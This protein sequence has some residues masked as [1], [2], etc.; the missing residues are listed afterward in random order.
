MRVLKKLSSLGDKEARY[1]MGMVRGINYYNQGK[2]KL[3]CKYLMKS[4][5]D[6]DTMGIG[7]V[8]RCLALCYYHG[9]GVK[10][11][12]QSAFLLFSKAFY[13]CDKESAKYLAVCY[14]KGQGVNKDQAKADY[15][16]DVV[17]Q[18]EN[19]NYRLSILIK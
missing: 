14:E 10:R 8:I 2:Y 7:L 19:G 1:R 6:P 15:F 11:N 17:K 13:L 4:A 16:Y 3:A 18:R 5:N 9:Q 12:Y